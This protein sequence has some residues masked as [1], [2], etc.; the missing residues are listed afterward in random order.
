MRIRDSVPTSDLHVLC[1]RYLLIS[2][3][4]LLVITKMDFLEYPDITAEVKGAMV[5]FVIIISFA[6][7]V[8]FVYQLKHAV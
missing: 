2:N 3:N 5:S 8:H 6:M 1:L 7:K 4:F